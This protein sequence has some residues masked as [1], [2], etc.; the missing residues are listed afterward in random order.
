M[1]RCWSV[2]GQIPCGFAGKVWGILVSANPKVVLYWNFI[3]SRCIMI[4]W[5]R[6]AVSCLCLSAVFQLS[7]IVEQGMYSEN[8][9]EPQT[10]SHTVCTDAISHC[11]SR[12]SQTTLPIAWY[13]DLGK[14]QNMLSGWRRNR[15][16]RIAQYCCFRRR[17][18]FPSTSYLCRCAQTRCCAVVFNSF[19]THTNTTANAP[20]RTSDSGETVTTSAYL[21][22]RNSTDIEL[23]PP[24]LTRLPADKILKA[25]RVSTQELGA[26]QTHQNY[27]SLSELLLTVWLISTF[28]IIV[29]LWK[30]N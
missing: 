20:L 1:R 27:K 16:W 28:Q 26:R 11:L 15:P 9:G 18:R 2:A 5:G 22:L 19:I 21:L 6:E 24:H 25:V 8:A 12:A 14:R 4:A 3:L 23:I 29:I 13:F 17:R 10:M 30:T 7:L